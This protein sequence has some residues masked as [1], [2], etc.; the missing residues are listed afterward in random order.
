A[1]RRGR[2]VARAGGAGSTGSYWVAT[3][4]REAGLTLRD[5]DIVNLPF[6]DMVTAF[7]AS[8]IDAAFPPAPFTTEILRDSTADNF[9]GPIRPGAAAGGTL[10]G[11][12]FMRERDAAARRGFVAL[13]RGARGVQGGGYCRDADPARL[14]E[15]P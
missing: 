1:D 12:S 15:Y 3:K 13:V 8:A 9:G 2:K 6:P 5:I 7:K 14:A 10:Y 11:V 4:L